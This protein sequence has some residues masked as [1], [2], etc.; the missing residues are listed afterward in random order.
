MR[1][2]AWAI[3]A[4]IH[5]VTIRLEVTAGRLRFVYSLRTLRDGSIDLLFMPDSS[6]HRDSSTCAAC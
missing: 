6:V 1:I 3:R 4:L 2:A 5:T